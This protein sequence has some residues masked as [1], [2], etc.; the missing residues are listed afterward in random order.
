MFIHL[1]PTDPP[2]GARTAREWTTSTSSATQTTAPSTLKISE[3]N[4]ASSATPTL[5]SKMPNT[6]GCPTSIP[7]VRWKMSTDCF[8]LAWGWWQWKLTGSGNVHSAQTQKHFPA[9]QQAHYTALY[10]GDI[11]KCFVFL[12][13]CPFLFAPLFFILSFISPP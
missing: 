13:C 2:T 9:D 11:L 12:S 1:L 7:T 10:K 4:S 6:T 5:N 3:P 8:V